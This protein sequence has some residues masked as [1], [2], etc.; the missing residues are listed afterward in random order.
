MQG[1]IL[2]AGKGTRLRPVTLERSKAMVPIVGKPMV[3]RVIET[4]LANQIR[5]FVVVIGPDDP[6]IL[7]YFTETAHLPA[8][9]QFVVQ[10]E[11]LGMANALALAAPFIRGDFLVSACD[12]IVPG[13]HIAALQHTFRSRQANA[14]LS[15]MKLPPARI[16]K[17]SAVEIR[18]EEITRI[19]EKPAPHEAPSD[20]GSLPL[21]IFSRHLLSY[22]EEVTP[23]PR[24]EYEL[25]DAIQMLID[26]RG[27]VA[28]V[29]T[30]QRVQLTNA[31]DLLSLT[32][33]YLNQEPP[34]LQPDDIGLNTQLISPLR[35][36]AQT[37]IGANCVIGPNVY[38]EPG[39]RI[40]DNVRLENTVV[41]RNTI[42]DAKQSFK[43]TIVH[44]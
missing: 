24:G 20:I 13:S 22:L 26:R 18:N 30:E 40:E 42:I 1:V 9:F 19:V 2:A 39:C 44:R 28:G 14:V 31:Q 11:R 23:S 15:L 25:Q 6:D 36:E 29:L 5:Q 7:P 37:S 38:I 34:H 3:E 27:G 43:D 17:S 35:I 41:L 33:H 10:P 16:S 21:Y 32:R 12:S 8:E 4:L